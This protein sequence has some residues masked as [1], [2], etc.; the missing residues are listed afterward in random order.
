LKVIK[1]WRA[2][3]RSQLPRLPWLL[4]ECVIGGAIGL[5]VATLWI[6]AV[7]WR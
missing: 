6:H 3:F 4:A 7:G 2:A 5:L 1:Q